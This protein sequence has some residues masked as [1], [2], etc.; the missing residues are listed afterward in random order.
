MP[1]PTNPLH[2]YKNMGRTSLLENILIFEFI[3]IVDHHS[4]NPLSNNKEIN[5]DTKLNAY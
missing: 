2:A 1:D 4:L 5:D 3:V